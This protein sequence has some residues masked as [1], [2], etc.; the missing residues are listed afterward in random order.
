MLMN[1]QIR[2]YAIVDRIDIE[3]D[4]G[5]TVLTGKTGAGKALLL[6]ALCPVLGAA[7]GARTSWGGVSVGRRVAWGGPL[8]GLVRVLAMYVFTS[9][10]FEVMSG[11]SVEASGGHL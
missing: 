7:G 6:H 3:F 8:A 9:I 11:L 5:M 4:S 10:A 1:L 2:D